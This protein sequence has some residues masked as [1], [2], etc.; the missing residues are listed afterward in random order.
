LL[1]RL[2]RIPPPKPGAREETLI[3]LVATKPAR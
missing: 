3:N 1:E 2:L